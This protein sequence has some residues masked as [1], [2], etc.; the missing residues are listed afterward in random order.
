MKKPLF[1][2]MLMLG[3]VFLVPAQSGEAIDLVVLLDTSASMSD[4]YRAVSDY[5]IGPFLKEFLRIGDTFHLI[6]FSSSSKLEISRRVEG[7]GDVE[8]I[9]GRILLMYP[10]D[11]SSDLSGALSFAEHYASSIPT[12][13]RKKIVLVSD[14]NGN[15]AAAQ[16]LI[17]EASARLSGRGM[18]LQHVKVPISGTPLASGRPPARPSPEQRPAPPPEAASPARPVPPVEAPPPARPA[19]P[20]EAVPPAR[21]VPP[22]EAAPPARPAPPAETGSPTRP[23]PAQG[24]P[25]AQAPSP[26]DQPAPQAR[27][28]EDRPVP[29]ASQDAGSP[30]PDEIP[31]SLPPE[32]SSGLVREETPPLRAGS[33]ES[34]DIP[35]TRQAV[36]PRQTPREETPRQ[37][38][39]GVSSSGGGEGIFAGLSLP[40][41]L[42]IGLGIG[43]LLILALVIFLVVRNLHGSPKRVMAA[44]TASGDNLKR[45][46]EE[47]ENQKR[48][49]EMMSGFAASRKKSESLPLSYPPPK[50]K[51]MPRD[52]PDDQSF[53]NGPPMLS[54]F[55]EDQN[56]AIGRRNIHALKP[57]Y[58]FSVGGGKSDFLIFLVPIPPRI[59]EVHFD[60]KQCTFIPRKPQYF[61]DIGSQAVSNCIGKTIRVISDKRYELHIRMERYE[62]PLKA[63][64]KLLHSISVSG[65][66]E[67]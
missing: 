46:E 55:V 18:E 54:L 36:P 24:T 16:G 37:P 33:G 3:I 6:S 23:A 35:Q 67:H 48:S 34:P 52:K 61:P 30:G 4:S 27:T 47:R 32:A 12:E 28:P 38:A 60:G 62:D 40:L 43:A 21:P 13:R 15:S 20:A 1:L 5:L 57:G 51:P 53:D 59:G 65:E 9:I 31:E 63:L 26:G 45:V 39:R 19:P 11:P 25:P 14:G 56:T 17:A 50:P 10:L 64:N 49:A 2:I 29:P 7:V 22:A 41:P 66:V 44:A 8:T 42:I 58:T